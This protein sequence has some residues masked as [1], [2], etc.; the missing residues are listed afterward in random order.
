M[1]V[2]SYI[3]YLLELCSAQFGLQGWGRGT[4]SVEYSAWYL[5]NNSVTLV[6][7]NPRVTYLT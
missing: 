5:K 4:S 2:I 7:H 3:T 1:V 6:C